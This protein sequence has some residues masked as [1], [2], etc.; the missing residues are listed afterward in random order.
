MQEFGKDAILAQQ[1][2]IG[3][4]V[5][6]AQNKGQSDAHEQILKSSDV[7]PAAGQGLGGADENKLASVV[8]SETSFMSASG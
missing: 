5:A 2:T 3:D 6:K 1:H 8:K 7:R 4:L